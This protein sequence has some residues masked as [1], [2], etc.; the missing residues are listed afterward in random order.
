MARG[1][2]AAFAGFS[3]PRTIETL[4]KLCHDAMAQAAGGAPRYFPREALPPAGAMDRLGE[5]SRSLARLARHDEH[6]WQ[7]AL[8]CDALVIEAHRALT[9]RSLPR[10]SLDTLPAS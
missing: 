2:A 6:P 9:A 5:W 10:T 4:Q 8:L 7:P 3:V 1:D